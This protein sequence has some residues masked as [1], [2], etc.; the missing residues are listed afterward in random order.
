[1][2]SD[3]GLLRVSER[4]FTAIFVNGGFLAGKAAG[5]PS[6]ALLAQYGHNRTLGK[7]TGSTDPA[8]PA[9]SSIPKSSSL[10]ATH[11]SGRISGST[12]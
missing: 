11:R 7:N 1:M 4:Q 5:R 3:Q 9:L 10:L 6:Y 2:D 8:L 12:A